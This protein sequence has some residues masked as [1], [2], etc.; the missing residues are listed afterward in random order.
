MSLCAPDFAVLQI[1]Y[2]RERERVSISC[3]DTKYSA[4]ISPGAL[5]IW[6][7]KAEEQARVQEEAV[8]EAV[9]KA[10][11]EYSVCCAFRPC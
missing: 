6:K 4:H 2:L 8:S 7:R 1:P 10:R 5:K 3:L 11:R 9:T